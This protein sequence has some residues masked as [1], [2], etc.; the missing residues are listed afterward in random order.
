MLKRCFVLWMFVC[1]P[2]HRSQGMFQ[3]SDYIFHTKMVL[4]RFVSSVALSFLSYRPTLTS[5]ESKRKVELNMHSRSSNPAVTLL[6]WFFSALSSFIAPLHFGF[7]FYFCA[8]SPQHKV[9]RQITD[10]KPSLS[11]IISSSSSNHFC[12]FY[13]FSFN[14]IHNRLTRRTRECIYVT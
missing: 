6:N 13:I 5:L 12:N 11:P 3:E 2:D 9:K 1:R 4:L 7:F 8:M 14:L 10:R